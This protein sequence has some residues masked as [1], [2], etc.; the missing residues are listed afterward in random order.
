MT[1]RII[2]AKDIVTAVITGILMLSSTGILDASAK[3]VAIAATKAIAGC[4]L[5]MIAYEKQATKQAILPSKL[6][7]L[8]LYFLLPKRIP[9]IAA[10]VSPKAKKDNEIKAISLG[11]RAIVNTLAVSKKDAPVRLATSCFLN[12][13][14]N[15]R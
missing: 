1:G 3:A 2:E 13:I 11:N 4:M 10:K 14:P 15:I 7:W 6:L 12:I 5:N 8:F 9:N